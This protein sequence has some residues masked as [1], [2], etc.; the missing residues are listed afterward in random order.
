M[1]LYKSQLA[2]LKDSLTDVPPEVYSKD[3]KMRES[4]IAKLDYYL[5]NNDCTVQADFKGC[6][7]ETRLLLIATTKELDAAND[8][9]NLLNQTVDRFSGNINAVIDNLDNDKADEINLKAKV[10]AKVKP[11]LEQK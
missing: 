6:Y 3:W 1:D 4:N 5:T 8:H 10:S 2:S 9:I 7:R 11:L